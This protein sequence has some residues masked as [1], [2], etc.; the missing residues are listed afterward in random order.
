MSIITFPSYFFLSQ[1]SEIGTRESYPQPESR[2]ISEATKTRQV[3]DSFGAGI[4]ALGISLNLFISP[5]L[6]TL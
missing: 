5:V 2:E 1:R 3:L 4:R 6:F